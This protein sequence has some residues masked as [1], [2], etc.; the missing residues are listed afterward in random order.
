MSSKISLY[1]SSLSQH[2]HY[3]IIPLEVAVVWKLQL[4]N[5]TIKTELIRTN[6]NNK[7]CQSHF[8][9]HILILNDNLFYFQ[10]LND[11]K[12]QDRNKSHL[13]FFTLHEVTFQTPNKKENKNISTSI[14][15]AQ[16][17]QYNLGTRYM[18]KQI[19]FFNNTYFTE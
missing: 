17:T 11:C 18:I 19:L 5:W 1:Y 16:N 10:H 8:F 15:P 2:V 13:K 4:T 6:I 12:E 7:I 9:V 14:R 3:S